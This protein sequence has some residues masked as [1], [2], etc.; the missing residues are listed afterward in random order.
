MQITSD[1]SPHSVYIQAYIYRYSKKYSDIAEYEFTIEKLDTQL[2][3]LNFFTN[4]TP[5]DYKLKVK[6]NKDEQK[7]DYEITRNVTVVK[8]KEADVPQNPEIVEKTTKE[9]PKNSSKSLNVTTGPVVYQSNKAKSEYMVPILII[10][11]LAAVS[12]ILIWKR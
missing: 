10:V 4:A 12:G 8:N 6:I 7:T 2:V 11:I 3:E 1:D 5:G 9:L